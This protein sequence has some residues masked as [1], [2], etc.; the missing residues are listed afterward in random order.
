MDEKLYLDPSPDQSKFETKFTVS[1]DKLELYG[2]PPIMAKN[3]ELI[4]SLLD[5][6]E[7][8]KANFLANNIPLG[9]K[10]SLEIVWLYLNREISSFSA[11]YTGGTVDANAIIHMWPWLN[12]FDVP[13]K[14]YEIQ[15]YLNL[16]F[17]VIPELAKS[18]NKDILNDILIK[19]KIIY[20]K[21]SDKLSKAIIEHLRPKENDIKLILYHPDGPRE[22]ILDKRN[23]LYDELNKIPGA[24]VI[25]RSHW[26]N[27][28]RAV[29]KIF[30]DF[31]IPPVWRRYKDGLVIN[32][33]G[34]DYTYPKKVGDKYVSLFIEKP[35]IL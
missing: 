27:D 20:P 31:P 24:A 34:S 11:L 3:S 29:Y 13:Y 7:P 9:N 19:T 32:L 26:S 12:Y 5:K 33:K 35:I 17:H 8:G 6:L 25:N 10:R 15:D 4:K 22:F 1:Q 23:S 21:V 30:S 28:E 18:E 14:T 16:L 2:F